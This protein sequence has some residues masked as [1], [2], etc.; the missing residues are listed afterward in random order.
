MAKPDLDVI[1]NLQVKNQVVH[2]G[3]PVVEES[4]GFRRGIIFLEILKQV[5]QI[6][7][8]PVVPSRN[9]TGKGV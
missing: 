1:L 4:Q 6:I 5:G 7:D 9:C 8:Y 2:I 3:D